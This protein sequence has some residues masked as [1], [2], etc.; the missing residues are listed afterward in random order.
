[1]TR[2]LFLFPGAPVFGRR[3]RREVLGGLLPAPAGP[4]DW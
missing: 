2:P 1:V 4:S 3:A